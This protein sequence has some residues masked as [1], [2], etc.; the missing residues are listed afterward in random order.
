MSH[1]IRSFRFLFLLLV[2]I[3]PVF[4]ESTGEHSASGREIY[5]SPDPRTFR[6]QAFQRFELPDYWGVDE[7]CFQDE[8]SDHD[9][10]VREDYFRK[11]VAAAKSVED[12]VRAVF[13]ES[14][15]L[16]ILGEHHLEKNY[17]VI[18]PGLLSKLKKIYPRLKY[19]FWEGSSEDESMLK[20][21]KNLENNFSPDV[22][23][24]AVTAGFSFEQIHFV[25]I[26]NLPDDVNF[27]NLDSLGDTRNHVRRNRVMAS[28]IAKILKADPGSQGILIV[29]K[30][31]I[32]PMSYVPSENSWSTPIPTILK[33]SHG[34]TARSF[35]LMSGYPTEPNIWIIDRRELGFVPGSSSIVICGRKSYPGMAFRVYTG[36]WD[37]KKV[38]DPDFYLRH[39]RPMRWG[40]VDGV[41]VIPPVRYAK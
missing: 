3:Q 23:K 30:A 13:L 15:D 14:D 1:G 28:N 41:L 40:E 9:P 31:H 18:Y 32:F 29:G 12:T 33:E 10:K 6:K 27:A 5:R 4:G 38:N 20:A 34:I 35:Y 22:M 7:I 25:D 8:Y 24:A 19:L 17:T 37:D 36:I 39:S 11:Q 21:G 26:E 16:L 2:L